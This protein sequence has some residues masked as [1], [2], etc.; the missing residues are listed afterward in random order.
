MTRAPNMDDFDAWLG[1]V[2]AKAAVIDPGGALDWKDI[3]LGFLLAR[4]VDPRVAGDWG[5]CA[6]FACGDDDDNADRA[7]AAIAVAERC[8]LAHD[9][10]DRVGYTKKYREAFVDAV[11][12][13]TPPEGVDLAAWV[14]S[15]DEAA[16]A[17]TAATATTTPATLPASGARSKAARAH[18]KAMTAAGR[19]AQL[20]RIDRERGAR[21][22]ASLT[23]AGTPLPACAASGRLCNP[24]DRGYPTTTPCAD[25]RMF[26]P[27]AA[28]E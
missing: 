25:L 19:A 22:I 1:A 5:L 13:T 4:G 14:R 27:G 10:A 2:Y 18:L 28:R 15:V 23:A 3:A 17:V 20:E 9:W 6:A 8:W 16:W 26:D 24:H 12:A 7:A 11:N 21:Y